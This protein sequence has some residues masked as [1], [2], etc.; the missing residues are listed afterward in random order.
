M[1]AR[2][3]GIPQHAASEARC[4][5]KPLRQGT[6]IPPKWTSF[7]AHAAKHRLTMEQARKLYEEIARLPIWMNEL[8]TVTV[9]ELDGGITHLSIRRNDRAPCR[10]WRHF[11]QIKNQLCGGSREAV[12]LYPAESRVVDAANQYHLWVLPLGMSL[13]LGFPKGAC[14]YEPSSPDLSFKQRPKE[15]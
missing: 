11:Q 10:D 7:Y 8:Y 4:T 14:S 2:T 1:L 3:L 15:G 9:R 5:V 13:P 6:P 12:E